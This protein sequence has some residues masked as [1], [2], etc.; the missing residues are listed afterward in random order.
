MP[1]DALHP[2]CC[3]TWMG[4]GVREPIGFNPAGKE[5]V[6]FEVFHSPG[7]SAARG[8]EPACNN[9]SSPAI[10]CE[11]TALKEVRQFKPAPEVE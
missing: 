10:T 5:S 11:I 8:R 6:G 9:L 1:E 2:S 7:Q 3:T 4:T